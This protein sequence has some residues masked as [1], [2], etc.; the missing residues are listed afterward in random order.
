MLRF[1]ILRRVLSSSRLS[2]AIE[3]GINITSAGGLTFRTGEEARC[4]RL[5]NSPDEQSSSHRHQAVDDVLHFRAI[6]FSLDAFHTHD[7]V[8]RR[9][10]LTVNTQRLR[11]G[12]TRE[13]NH[14]I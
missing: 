11:V 12:H 9:A 7:L 2:L 4:C 14:R 3:L 8:H 10:L 5:L 13:S 6:Q 1:R